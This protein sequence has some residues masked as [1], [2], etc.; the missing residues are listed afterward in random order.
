VSNGF[1]LPVN[2]VLH[3]TP[4]NGRL[5]IDDDT[6]KTVPAGATAKLLVPVKARVGNGKVQLTMELFSPQGVK[7]GNTQKA[8]VDVHAEWESLGALI[9]GILAVL[10]FGFGIFRSIR[11][12]RRERAVDDSVTEPVEVTDPAAD[13]SV[14]EPVEVTNDDPSTTPGTDKHG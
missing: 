3:T 13:N 2:V 7:I 6:P 12:R 8:T 14:T 11:R 1:T 10:L 5:E 4:S 9:I